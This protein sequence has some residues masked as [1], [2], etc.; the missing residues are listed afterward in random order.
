MLEKMKDP[1]LIRLKGCQ[2]PLSCKEIFAHI[3]EGCFLIG[4][5]WHML[6]ALSLCHG[7]LR[8]L[9]HVRLGCSEW[10]HTETFINFTKAC[11]L[12]A[13]CNRVLT[14]RRISSYNGAPAGT[15][16][17]DFVHLRKVTLLTSQARSGCPE[18]SKWM[19]F[20]TEEIHNSLNDYTLSKKELRESF[21][22][23]ESGKR[24]LRSTVSS[25]GTW[26]MMGVLTFI[27]V[28]RLHN[29]P[30]TCFSYSLHIY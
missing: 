28:E 30:H 14:F 19:S 24:E 10:E 2:C 13:A 12:P 27:C 7:I 23:K 20:Y 21:P 11:R 22:F 26:P 8:R 18:L 6:V 1:R 17:H 29:P 9:S 15:K 5:T 3:S 16:P 4:Q 25:G